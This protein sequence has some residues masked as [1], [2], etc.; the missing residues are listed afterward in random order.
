MLNSKQR[1]MI[2][3]H[4]A[5]EPAICFVGKEGLSENCITSITQALTAREAIKIAVLQ[6]CDLTAREV[7]DEIERTIKADIVSVMGKKIIAYKYSAHAKKH[8]DISC[9]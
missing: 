8:I 4:M 7:A 5:Q 9:Q 1:A 6:N 3:K 2:K